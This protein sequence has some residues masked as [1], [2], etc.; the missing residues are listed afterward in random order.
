METSALT[1][2]IGYH[3]KP[4]DALLIPSMVYYS[5]PWPQL[6]QKLYVAFLTVDTERSHFFLILGTFLIENILIGKKIKLK[7]GYIQLLRPK[8][9]RIPWLQRN[10]FRFWGSILEFVLTI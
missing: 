1:F 2:L 6:P 7:N 10:A 8:W 3:M 5:M 4:R 9:L